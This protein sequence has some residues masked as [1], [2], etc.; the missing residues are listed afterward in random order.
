MS[1]E[2]KITKIIETYDSPS[3]LV[4]SAYPD[5]GTEP[6][7]SRLE[8][9]ASNQACEGEAAISRYAIWANTVRDTIIECLFD[10]GDDPQNRE[11]IQKLVRAANSLSAFA[12]IQKL[13]APVE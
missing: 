3:L 4:S 5:G 7:F 8:R 1:I 6:L 9:A 13:M 2:K 11:V 12:E 10:L